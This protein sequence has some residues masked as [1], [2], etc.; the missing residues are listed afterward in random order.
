MESEKNFDLKNSPISQLSQRLNIISSSQLNQIKDIKA[1]SNMIKQKHA[2]FEAKKQALIKEYHSKTQK[3]IE[4]TEENVKKYWKTRIND[5]I[6]KLKENESINYLHSDQQIE[7]FKEKYKNSFKRALNQ[8]EKLIYNELNQKYSDLYEHKLENIKSQ[9]NKNRL[10]NQLIAEIESEQYKKII[11]EKT[12]WSNTYKKS[13]NYKALKNEAILSEI[14]LVEQKI[15]KKINSKTRETIESIKKDSEYE[16]E[17]KIKQVDYESFKNSDILL[18][19]L[20]KEWEQELFCEQEYLDNFNQVLK[21]K[22]EI[23]SKIK[24]EIENKAISQSFL[25]KN[26][27]FGE[28]NDKF[29]EAHEEFQTRIENQSKNDLEKVEKNLQTNFLC[30]I[31]ELAKE[32]LKPIEIKLKMKYYKKL[33]KNKE[34]IQEMLKQRFLA[35]YKVVYI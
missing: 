7:I 25:I 17:E 24:E 32:K 14:Q 21:I 16:I 31:Q 5:L 9:Y 10:I 13:A 23:V 26:R 29:Q 11:K 1:L 18:E 28:L 19:K 6:Y 27:T 35:E 30:K 15:K 8:W 22:S 33:E 20:K 3:A 12:F 4:N 2:E 34:D